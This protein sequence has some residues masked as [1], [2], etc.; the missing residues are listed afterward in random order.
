M[1]QGTRLTHPR[2]LAN[3]MHA[4]ILLTL[5][6]CADEN[7][8]GPV[9]VFDPQSA[10][11]FDTPWPDDRRR[12]ADGTLKLGTFPNP[13]SVGIL[14]NYLAI[15]EALPGFGTNTPIY[16]RFA[17]P[18]DTTLLPTPAHSLADD[19]P[20]LLLDVGPRSSHRGERFPVHWS[21]QEEGTSYTADNLLA[22]APLPGFPLRPDTTYALV[23]TTAIAS[24][25]QQANAP[26]SADHPD[27]ARHADLL[28]EL[29]LLGLGPDD[30]AIATVFTTRDP[31]DEMARL[32]R[33][34]Q[35]S[36]EPPDLDQILEPLASFTHYDAWRTH[37][38]SPVFTHGERPFLAEGG[39]FRFR[40]DGQPVI[41]WWDDLRL[42]VCTPT[43]LTQPPADG[44]PVV[45]YQHGTGGDYRTFCD[46]DAPLEVA[47]RMG[48]AGLITVGIDQPLHDTRNGGQAQ[49]DLA[50]FNI[51]NPVSG[52]TNFRQGAVDALYLARA[53][54][55]ATF[56]LPSGQAV[57]IDGDRVLFFGHSQGGLTG[58]I[59]APWLGRD[60]RAA[61]L[62]GTGGVLAIT[63]VERKDILDFTELLRGWLQL[64]DDDTVTVFHPTVAL[65]QTLVEETDPVNYA[66]YW[67]SEQGD[68]P[69]HSPLPVMLT[70]GTLD[71]NTPY[72]SAVALAA[73]A[74]LPVLAPAATSLDAIALRGRSVLPGPLVDNA[75]TFDGGLAA[76]AF[77]QWLD[78]S[79]FI[80][81]REE[82]VSDLVTDYLRSTADGTP[83][84]GWRGGQ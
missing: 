30:V 60:A 47:N 64:E 7:V 34:V 29:F 23:I 26:L 3:R 48:A 22:V 41:A 20:V 43:D 61:V 53:L 19:S 72:R 75:P 77:V 46:S 16:V 24:P 65:L 10:V 5:A 55:E 1:W 76:A 17:G 73:A 31:L 49:S 59:A 62:S 63:V 4:W 44:W 71:A 54:Q 27:H 33:F 70:N 35:E 2:G 36:I 40:D 28:R 15:A 45:I 82:S 69:D 58:A 74:R 57:P 39:E 42:S 67:F 6:G 37:Y 21:Y 83:I 32:A 18:L 68:W 52:A 50:N 14:D 13:R 51:V 25:N 80:V 11:F 84:I 78:G 81:F 56:T 66:P 9:P 12:R 38:P 79:H 8:V